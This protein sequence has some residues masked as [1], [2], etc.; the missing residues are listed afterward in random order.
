[1]K[2]MIA[3]CG[4][5]CEK[6]DA[7]LATVRDDQALREK[8]A[9]AWSELNHVP[10][11][12]EHINCL[13]C[14]ADGIKTV[15]CDSL[16]E[17]RQCALK[18]GAQTCGDCEELEKCRTVGAILADN[19]EALNNL[20][21]QKNTTKV[22]VSACL[23]GENCKYNGGNN[24]NCWRDLATSM[25]SGGSAIATMRKTEMSCRLNSPIRVHRKLWACLRQDRLRGRTP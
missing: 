11:L 17:I 2:K 3:Y 24:Y 13:G 16:C 20:K 1:M 22:L 23:L 18:K 15:F 10:I 14:R 21:R 25:W 4:L 12:P 7:Y 19:P 6:C 5:D 8:T 9:K